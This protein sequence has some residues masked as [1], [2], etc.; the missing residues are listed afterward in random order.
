MDRRP[1][2]RGVEMPSLG[3]VPAYKGGCLIVGRLLVQL[4]GSKYSPIICREHRLLR[5]RGF[6]GISEVSLSSRGSTVQH[7]L[8]LERQDS[9]KHTQMMVH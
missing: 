8:G 4:D 9:G 2:R 7:A 1:L 6:T 5:F 3:C